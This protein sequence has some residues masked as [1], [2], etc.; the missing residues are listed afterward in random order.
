M[1]VSASEHSTA[2]I[3]EVHVSGSERSERSEGLESMETELHRREDIEEALRIRG[4]LVL[5][6][7]KHRIT[8]RSV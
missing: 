7:R 4:G 8:F 6:K 3:R 2:G 1:D 5:L